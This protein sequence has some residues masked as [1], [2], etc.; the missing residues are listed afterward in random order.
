MNVHPT[1]SL[2]RPRLADKVALVTGA[3]QGI[4]RATAVR[5]AAEGASVGILDRAEDTLEQTA[6]LVRETGATAIPLVADVVDGDSVRNAVAELHRVAGAI[7]ILINNAGLDRPGPFLKVPPDDF[8]TVLNVHLLGTTNCCRSC[9]TF[10]IEQE[11]GRIVNVSS[12]Y[13]KV[14]SRS[15]SAYATAKAAIIGLT[16]SLAQ[17]WASKGVRVNAIL[18]GLT[19]TPTIRQFMAEKIKTRILKETP[20]GRWA[21]ASEIAAP[22]AF[23]A[24]DEAS[25]ITGATL[26]VSGG[27]H[28]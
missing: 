13:G 19:D 26:E 24:S 6:R 21:D 4:G 8:L 27:W 25:F 23:L 17:E 15:E 11:D 16:K 5:L 1:D 14:G 7:H 28:M 2:R 10:M 20:L 12:I 22:I 3:G 18:P 9:A